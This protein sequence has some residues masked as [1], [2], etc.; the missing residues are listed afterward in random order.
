MPEYQ[1]NI[2][3]WLAIYTKP[4]NE[5]K[6]DERLSANGLESYCPTQLVLK[7]WSDRKKKVRLPLFTSYV[8][9]HV[10][11]R[12]RLRVLQDPGVLN[13]VFWQGKPAVI[14]DQEIKNIRIFLEDFDE[15]DV[16]AIDLQRG[17]RLRVAE[18]ALAGLEGIL[19]DHDNGYAILQIESIGYQLKAR[20]AITKLSKSHA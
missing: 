5:K 7:Q 4:R 3:Q 6:V 19:L 14:R 11:E 18:G 17:E 12:E 16:E 1:G 20:V 2:K 15:V 8:F 9:V 10:D 13:F